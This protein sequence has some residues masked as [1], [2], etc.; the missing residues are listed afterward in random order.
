[1]YTAEHV[2]NKYLEKME[3]DVTNA[4]IKLSILDK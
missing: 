4:K 2:T 3:T 1:M